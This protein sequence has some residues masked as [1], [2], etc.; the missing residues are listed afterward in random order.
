M[1]IKKKTL[2]R[3]V[4]AF[5]I[6]ILAVGIAIIL[7][8]TLSNYFNS[9]NQSK[10]ITDY[11]KTVEK[12][13]ESERK[14]RLSGAQNYNK[15][16]AEL[17]S[18]YDNYTSISGY[19][20]FLD[21]SNTGIMGYVDIPKINVSLP[22]YHST[23]PEVL[24]IAVGHLQGSSL[25]IGG[26]NTHSVISSHRGLPSS[27][28]FTD[29]DKLVEDDTFTITV[30]NEVMTYT[31][32]KIAVIKPHEFDELRV[33]PDGDYVT[34]MTCTPYGINT[35]RLLVRGR[36]IDNITESE[37][38]RITADAVEV[39]NTK[40]IGAISLPV[41]LLLLLYWTFSGKKQSQRTKKTIFTPKNTTTNERHGDQNDSH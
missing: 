23:S 14:K 41:V 39:D 13:D 18:P 17:A 37:V 10:A 3:L 11:A 35:H 38:I 19:D 12:M 6:V 31:V 34:L 1:K 7:Y 15:Q 27:R 8:P 16:L 4:I 20:N 21:V 29:I 40:F 32:D 26:K 2:D 36:R 5:M 9:R 33:I 22:I 30:L 28:L 24:N 25:P